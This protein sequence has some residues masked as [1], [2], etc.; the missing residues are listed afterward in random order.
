M[1]YNLEKKTSEGEEQAKEA[2][3]FAFASSGN[4]R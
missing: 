3:Y 4:D 2:S 1:V